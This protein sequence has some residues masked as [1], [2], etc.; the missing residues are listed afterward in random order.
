MVKGL[1]HTLSPLIPAPC[2]PL[3]PLD[4][5]NPRSPCATKSGHFCQLHHCL[6]AKYAL[7]S[8]TRAQK[9]GML[10]LVTLLWLILHDPT[11]EGSKEWNSLNSNVKSRKLWSDGSGEKQRDRRSRAAQCNIYQTHLIQ[12]DVTLLEDIFSNLRATVFLVRS[13]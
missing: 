8:V 13:T 2:C 1:K 7:F 11:Q 6:T 5:G 9:K 4:P 12:T 10:S 3:G